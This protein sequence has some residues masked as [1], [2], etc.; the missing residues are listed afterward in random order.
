MAKHDIVGKYVG[1]TARKRIEYIYKNYKDLDYLKESYRDYTVEMISFLKQQEHSHDDDLGVRVQTSFNSGSV[2]ERTAF[3]NIMIKEML[4]KNYVPNEF[5]DEEENQEFVNIA[6]FE[7]NL[8]RSE[9]AIF[10]KNLRTLSHVNFTIARAYLSREKNFEELGKEYSIEP[11]SVKMRMH[12]IKRQLTDK[13]IP[14]FAEYGFN[15]QTISA[16]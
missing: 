4:D 14:F 11:D 12:R 7:W 1:M 3:E 10:E 15:R 8:M 5:M 2:T 16:G 9:F 6:V 13:M